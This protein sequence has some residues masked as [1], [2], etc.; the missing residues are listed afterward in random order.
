MSTWHASPMCILYIY[1][2]II[3][4]YNYIYILYLLLYATYNPLNST[5]HQLVCSNVAAQILS[6]ATSFK[7]KTFNLMT[8]I[9]TWLNHDSVPN[10]MVDNM[11]IMVSSWLEHDWTMVQKKT[12]F[13]SPPSHAAIYIGL[14]PGLLA[15]CSM[16]RRQDLRNRQYIHVIHVCYYA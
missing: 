10:I 8:A 1:I 16:T 15:T 12:V 13:Q 6:I 5:C 3:L 9:K 2:Y 11:S 14:K 4:L 7:Q